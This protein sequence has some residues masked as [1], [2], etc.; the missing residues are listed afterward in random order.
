ME[1]T[2]LQNNKVKEW[3]KL[4]KKKYRDEMGLFIVEDEHL[5]E[6]ANKKQLVQTLL[7]QKGYHHSF[8]GLPEIIVTDEII[9]KLSST[10]S[11]NHILAICKKPI[12]QIE[13]KR[14]ILLDQVQDPGNVGTIIRTAYAFGFD[15]IILSKDC[16]DEYS[17]KV[18]RST[19]GAL[20]HINII[21]D[22][23]K[24][25]IQSL[26]K[27]GIKVYGTSLQG[28]KELQSFPQESLVS[29]VLGNE[30]NGVSDEILSLCDDKIYIEMNRFESLNV[31]IAGGILA[32][33]FRK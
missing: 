25:Q 11:T 14:C 29:F 1:I 17:S 21:R 27:R 2:S 18:I 20:F 23:L 30:G 7:V 22:D 3:M 12:Q 5:I 9:K 4:S 8:V 10:V 16:C 6:E 15:T 28:A 19:Q 26:Q 32:Y 13:P 31:A 24:E 33:Y